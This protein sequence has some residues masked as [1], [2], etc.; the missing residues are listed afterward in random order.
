M[1]EVKQIPQFDNEA[2][3]EGVVTE[4]DIAKKEFNGK[5]GKYFALSGNIVIQTAENETHKAQYFVK[6]LKKDGD[7]NGIY[8]NVETVLNELVTV[9]DIAQGKAP[10]GAVASK[11]RVRGELSLNEYYGQ[12]G[13]LR[14]FPQVKG[15][16]LNRVKDEAEYNPKATY[17]VEG[18]VKSVK[19]EFKDE[20]ETG[21]Q[22][23]ELL[24]PTYSGAIPVEFISRAEDGEYIADNFE[25]ATSVNLYGNMI[26]F[27]KKI[28]R[29][30]EKGF[31]EA[32][33]KVTYEN[34]RELQISGGSVYDED[35][36]KSLE[37]EQIQELQTKRNVYLAELESKQAEKDKKEEKP[38]GFGASTPN[39]KTVDKSIVAGLF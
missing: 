7:V 29:L 4:C 5:D 15:V 19:A 39:K 13:K 28:V 22:K 17:D 10:E 25:P 23:V 21:R 30:E 11:V 37:V 31:G 26:N 33:E 20:E 6:E 3:L 12:D 32:K 1:T 38:Q 36:P 35:S 27:S 24:I 2:I 9:Q 14:S 8:T 16:F 18:I 34:T